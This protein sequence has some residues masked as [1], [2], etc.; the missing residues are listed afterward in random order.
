LNSLYQARIVNGHTFVLYIY[1][2]IKKLE[3]VSRLL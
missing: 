2:F 3:A 1:I